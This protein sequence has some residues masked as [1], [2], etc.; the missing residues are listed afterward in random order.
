VADHPYNTYT[1]PGTPARAHLIAQHPRHRRRA[2]PADVNYLY[3]VARPDGT[4]VFNRHLVDHNR[5]RAEI[6][7]DIGRRQREDRRPA[8][9]PTRPP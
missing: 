8:G 6:R 4:H 7:R 2:H 1:Q 3:F 9:A 5:R